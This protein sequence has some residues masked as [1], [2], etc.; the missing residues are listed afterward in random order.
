MSAAGY[1][2]DREELTRAWGG[3]YLIGCYGSWWAAVPAA[4]GTVIA[5]DSAARLWSAL[6]AA[7]DAR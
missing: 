7:R 6:W 4:G 1:Y 3:T 2:G 5:A